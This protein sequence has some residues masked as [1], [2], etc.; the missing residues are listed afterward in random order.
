MNGPLWIPETFDNKKICCIWFL[1]VKP[2]DLSSCL[3]T[4]NY[5][6]GKKE[7]YYS[8]CKENLK[9]QVRCFSSDPTDTMEEWWGFTEQNDI[10][11]WMLKWL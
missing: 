3:I 9:G 6:Q 2:L 11:L 7:Y 8:W 10:M 4:D 5:P 1:K